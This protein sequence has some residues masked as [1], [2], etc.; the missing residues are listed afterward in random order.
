[1]D[2]ILFLGISTCYCF[3]LVVMCSAVTGL[4]H[5]FPSRN[6]GYGGSLS[7]KDAALQALSDDTWPDMSN[8][9][10]AKS[11][12]SHHMARDSPECHQDRTR[13]HLR[14][15]DINILAESCFRFDG[16][17]LNFLKARARFRD[18]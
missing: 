18:V 16:E 7:Y 6:G 9:G 10:I 2:N 17:K 13:E 1:M 12:L 14:I 3:N 8:P 5:C 4:S 11:Q 15:N